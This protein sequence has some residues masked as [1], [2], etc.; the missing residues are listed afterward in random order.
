MLS[1]LL[2]RDFPSLLKKADAA[3]EAGRWG[4]AKLAYERALGAKDADA[5]GRAAAERGL[6]RAKAALVAHNVAEAELDLEAGE[7]AQALDRLQTALSL[8]ADGKE[9]AA[10]RERI[11]ALKRSLR[12]PSQPPPLDDDEED[13]E[14]APTGD[15]LV[16]GIFEPAEE[17]QEAY[18]E[19]LMERFDLALLGLPE[20]L[21]ER[22]LELG[23]DFAEAYLAAVEERFEDAEA[24]FAGL[25]RRMS[26]VAIYH[27]ERGKTLAALGR[28]AEAER[29]LRR[30]AELDPRLED[31]PLSLARILLHEGK[32]PEARAVLADAGARGVD[33]LELAFLLV[34][35]DLAERSAEAAERRLEE[36]GKRAPEDWRVAD[37]LGRVAE[38]RGD[39]DGAWKH[40]RTALRR[41]P[42]NHDV[43]LRL[44]NVVA[45]HPKEYPKALDLFNQLLREEHGERWFLYAQI[46]RIYARKGWG[47][48][49]EEMLE[50]ALA[51]LPEERAEDRRAIEKALA[52]TRERP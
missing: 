50:Q 38:L 43:R 17:D 37:G 40:Y 9:A 1:K 47:E 7:P 11:G 3:A 21:G 32:A 46:G 18:G 31:A 34:E 23:E 13:E 48:R 49:A 22:Y 6:A 19:T 41:Q 29:A 15:E 30:A 28:D 10:L 44:A 36:A 45:R 16:E 35:C 24:A 25:E 26:G 51:L 42:K 20:A 2:G 27:L 39:L 14:E 4:D 5:E 12:D 33:A 52:E 8:A